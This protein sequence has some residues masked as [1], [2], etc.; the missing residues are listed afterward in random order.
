MVS[1]GSVRLSQPRPR[2]VCSALTSA[3]KS[4]S[5][6]RPQWIGSASP[7]QT[8]AQKR[9]ST[10][11]QYFYATTSGK[12]LFTTSTGSLSGSY[13]KSDTTAFSTLINP[14]GPSFVEGA[15]GTATSS[16]ASTTAFE[17]NGNF[18]AQ[19]NGTT[20]ACYSQTAGVVF[21][22]TANSHESGCNGSAWVKMF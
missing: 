8:A 17:V 18:R 15:N 22:N 21:Y 9:S 13:T 20:T 1:P 4:G 6:R 11:T 14:L 19:S 16:I 7:P 2:R 10:L 5:I 12:Y 3:Q